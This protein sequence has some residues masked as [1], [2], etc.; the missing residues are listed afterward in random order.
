[1]ELAE[2]QFLRFDH[3]LAFILGHQNQPHHVS[4]SR[5]GGQARAKSYMVTES[6]AMHAVKRVSQGG[7]IR[8]DAVVESNFVCNATVIL[9]ARSTS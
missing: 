5:P 4:A 2:E 3:I 9:S 7:A 6:A 1:M 8:L